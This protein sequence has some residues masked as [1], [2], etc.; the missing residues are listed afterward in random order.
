MPVEIILPLVAA[1]VVGGVLI[2]KRGREDKLDRIVAGLGGDFRPV[3]VKRQMFRLSGKKR[4]W[5]L[6]AIVTAA[7]GAVGFWFELPLWLIPVLSILAGLAA[8]ALI[9]RFRYAAAR[10]KFAEDF[11]DA[12]EN[13]ARAV[14]SGIPI[15]RALG[16][17][18]ELFQGEVGA[19]FRHMVRQL[20]LGVPFRNALSGLGGRY[21]LPDVDFFCAVLSLNRDTGGPLS[22]IL[23]SLSGTLRARQSAERR[24]QVLTAE[25][26]A[27]AR[28]V[29]MLPLAIIGLQLV[30]N[31]Q[32]ITFM[33]YDDSGRQVFGYCA[34]CIVAGLLLIRRMSRF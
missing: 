11:P 22:Q 31:P 1:I 5:F 24:L 20:E 3:A 14:Q 19:S 4:D 10:K 33:F 21:N 27:S 28:I 9:V 32:Q 2:W 23:G 12:V 16:G 26:R 34:L 8:K 17:L 13:L 18:G 7:T 6:S 29:A 15:E 30:L 25:A